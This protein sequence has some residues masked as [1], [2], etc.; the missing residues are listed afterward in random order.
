MEAAEKNAKELRRQYITRRRSKK[1]VRSLAS[2]VVKLTTRKNCMER[3]RIQN[4]NKKTYL[5]TR[6]VYL[7]KLRQPKN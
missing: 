2:T 6:D 4:K 1:A 5:S 3:K 7:S